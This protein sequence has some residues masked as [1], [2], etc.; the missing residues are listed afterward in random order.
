MVDLRLDGVP[1]LITA[2]M[3]PR[4]QQGNVAECEGPVF[5]RQDSQIN[6]CTGH[7]MVSGMM[8]NCGLS[9]QLRYMLSIVA[10]ALLVAATATS[11]G[12]QTAQAPAADA[13]GHDVGPTL[14]HRSRYLV[15]PADVLAVSFPLTPEFNQSLTVAPDGFVALQGVGDLSIAGKSLPELREMLRKAYSGILHDPLVNVDLKDFQKPQFTVSGQVGHPG[16]YD[17]REDVTVAEALA[18]AGGATTDAKSS[19]VLLF[20]RVPGGSLMEVRKLNLKKMLGEGDLTEDV[21]LEPGDLLY[22][23]KSTIGKIARFLPSSSIGIYA[24]P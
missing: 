9:V 24:V 12:G 20:R 5:L 11:C 10:V 1:A 18:Q 16:K 21:H 14:R 4:V 17:I 2:R 22:V 13:N 3:P 7:S 19:Q 8:A 6:V 15:Q 23:P